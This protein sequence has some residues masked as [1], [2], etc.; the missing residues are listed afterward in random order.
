MAFAAVGIAFGTWLAGIVSKKMRR[1]KLIVL[2]LSGMILSLLPV[3]FL[4]IDLYTFALL[5]FLTAVSGGLF[6]VP[7]LTIIQQA[8]AGRRLGQLLAYMNLMVFIFVLI[9]SVVFS[10]ITYFF[11]E[12]SLA[13][14]FVIV[15]ICTCTLISSLIIPQNHNKHEV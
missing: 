4:K 14:F 13:V 9:A 6:Q 11:D 3:I 1:S 15:L 2:G 7:N 5:I 12:N 8:Q 10:G